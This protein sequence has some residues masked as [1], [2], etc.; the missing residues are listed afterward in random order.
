[1]P[2]AKAFGT[3]LK[4]DEVTNEWV[5]NQG[6]R[7]KR[8]YKVATVLDTEDVERVV[9]KDKSEVR[10]GIVLEGLPVRAGTRWVGRRTY[11]CLYEV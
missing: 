9:L 10:K 7:Q 8:S 1:M 3:V 2:I 11:S 6:G 4:V 5:D